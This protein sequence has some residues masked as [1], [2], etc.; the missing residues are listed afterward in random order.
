[1]LEDPHLNFAISTRSGKT[2]LDHMGK[3]T[4]RANSPSCA[5]TCQPRT[6]RP[7]A[8]ARRPAATRSRKN[9]GWKIRTASLGKPTTR[10]KM[11]RFTRA[12]MPL[13]SLP[14]APRKP[15]KAFAPI[16]SRNWRRLHPAAGCHDTP[17][18]Q[19]AF[20]LHWQFRAQHSGGIPAEPL[21]ARSLPWFQRGQLSERRNSP[22]RSQAAALT[23]TADRRIAQQE[24]G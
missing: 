5:S 24:L 2:G 1:M 23:R 7:I 18:V 3:L 9:H 10:W 8:T 22:L 13:P 4:M 20:S 14:A 16:Q 6:Y 21:G 11:R 19:R 15:R 12:V 17:S